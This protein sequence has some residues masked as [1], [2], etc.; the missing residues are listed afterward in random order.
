MITTYAA[1]PPK[2]AARLPA[3]IPIAIVAAWALAILAYATGRERLL[4]HHTLIEHGPPLWVGVLLFTVAW[5]SM[6]AA[7]MLPSTLPLIRMF[8]VAAQRQARPAL[9]M[10]TFLGGYAAV[11]TAFG[12]AAFFGDVAIHRTVDATP[13][14]SARPWLIGG[15]ALVIA[16]EFQFS[17]LKDRCLAKC[18]HPGGYLMAHYRRG[19]GGAFRL[20][21][22]H[23][24]FCLGCCWAL[25][26]VMFGAGVGALWWMAGLTAVMVYEK[27]GRHGA[28]TVPVVGI[29]LL[30]AG[31]LQLAHP[32]WLGSM[33]V[34]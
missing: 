2:R 5:Q 6:I 24:L 9:A 22:G 29:L 13:W 10:T 34:K 26:L 28:T 7:M 18:R 27:V 32:S 1:G 17:G 25:M 20:G 12:V 16:G 4:H 14:L 11:W 15:T 23:G 21:L 3:V 30:G 31:I 19:P 33:L 8:R